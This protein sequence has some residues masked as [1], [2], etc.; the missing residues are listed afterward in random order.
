MRQRCAAATAQA[1]GAPPRWSDRVA[2]DLSRILGGFLREP[3]KRNA[4]VPF[5]RSG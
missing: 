3:R 5:P 2:G 1:R 4:S